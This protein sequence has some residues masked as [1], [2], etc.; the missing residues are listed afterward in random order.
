MIGKLFSNTIVTEIDGAA[1]ERRHLGLQLERCCALIRRHSDCAA[2]RK[3]RRSSLLR[4]RIARM[5]HESARPLAYSYRRRC[6]NGRARSTRRRLHMLRLFHRV[7][8]RVPASTASGPEV[9][10]APTGATVTIRGS[11]VDPLARRKHR[12]P[13][14]RATA[15]QSASASTL[16]PSPTGHV[17]HAS[18]RA[19][20][21][22][23]LATKRCV[24]SATPPIVVAS[25]IPVATNE[26]IRA[27]RDDGDAIDRAV[28]DHAVDAEMHQ[29]FD[30][31]AHAA[32]R[33]G[34]GD[35]DVLRHV[36]PIEDDRTERA[37]FLFVE[38]FDRSRMRNER[39]PSRDNRSGFD[40]DA[41]LRRFID[42]SRTLHRRGQSTSRPIRR[43]RASATLK[44]DVTVVVFPTFFAVPTTMS[45]RASLACQRSKS[46]SA[47]LNLESTC[48]RDA[49]RRCPSTRA[50][51]RRTDQSA[52]PTRLPMSSSERKAPLS[53]PGSKRRIRPPSANDDV[54]A[55]IGQRKPDAKRVPS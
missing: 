51:S 24:A 1:R 35:L 33:R 45:E 48:A 22:R 10:S 43:P 25:D 34:A 50:K 20:P 13:V 17:V 32:R 27:G 54:H 9:S 8:A 23:S 47:M 30:N 3:L 39:A 21:I 44:S 4:E 42:R 38:N 26:R 18:T 36:R 49:R 5:R 14:M 2:G 6:G 31:G 46:S 19:E 55:Q 28:D 40:E 29:P 52:P 53:S 41:W 12:S 7:A 15:S 11:I 37:A 16:R